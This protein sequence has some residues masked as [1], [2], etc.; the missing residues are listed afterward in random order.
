[1]SS[2]GLLHMVPRLAEEG[3]CLEP[4]KVLLWP[5]LGIQWVPDSTDPLKCEEPS[6]GTF[7]NL[8][9][10]CAPPHKHMQ[11]SIST[12]D[13]LEAAHK[14]WIPDGDNMTRCRVE[15]LEDARSLV[16]T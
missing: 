2:W 4:S 13:S 14:N 15:K 1:M 9:K 5:Q 6:C 12:L 8:W 3:F 7:W 16:P 11:R 10:V